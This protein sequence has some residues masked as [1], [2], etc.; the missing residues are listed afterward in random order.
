MQKHI[1]IIGIGGIGI[2]ALARYYHYLGY[3]VTGS[4]STDSQLIQALKNENFEIFISTN[5]GIITA[6]T[7]KVI[8]SEAIITKP[9]LPK[10]LQISS[11]PEIARAIELNIPHFSYPVALARVFNE[12][13][14]IAVTGSHGKSTTTAMMAIVLK[15][16]EIGGSAIV[17]TQVPQLGN[18]NFYADSS[19]N[20]VIEACEYKRSFLNYRPFISIIINIDLDHLDYYKDLE[21]YISAFQSLVD[22]TSGFVIISENDKNSQLLKIPDEKKIIVGERISYFAKVEMLETDEIFYEQKF[23][24]IP[25]ISLKIP[26]DH[27]L[28]DAKLVYAAS[29]LLGLNDEEIIPSLQSYSGS[30]RRSEII[31]M[32][33]NGNILM[34][35][36]GHHPSEIIPTLSALKG[37]NPDK[38]LFVAFQPHQYSR[39]RE[40]LSL[41]AN[42]FQ[43]ADELVIP[44][45]Y[46]SRDKK[47]DV[48]FMTTDKLVAEIS[49]NHKN[50]K[51]GNSLENTVKIISDFDKKNPN[52]AII[53]LLGAGDIDTLR[54]KII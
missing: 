48:E 21:D 42:A 15:N 8:Y 17:G 11:H 22:Q 46:F 32:T 51:S 35:D 10:D 36:Y 29:R 45:I 44:N 50:V 1:H 18:T 54:D 24:E 34:S 41:F 9:D 13:K 16:S 19:E 6:E 31:R 3:R 26:G 53:L 40:L 43:S 39:T 4:D 20:F 47:E 7:E 33:K 37:Q 12:K 14:G 27:I 28:Q 5:P 2:S 25:Q 38:K 30:W 52:S 49:K 23:L